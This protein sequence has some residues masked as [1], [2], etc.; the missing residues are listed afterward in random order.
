MVIIKAEAESSG[1]FIFLIFIQPVALLPC[2]WNSAG[3]PRRPGRRV[4]AKLRDAATL[5][6]R[7]SGGRPAPM[8]CGETAAVRVGL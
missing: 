7:Q 1:R 5:G 6:R 4:S 2:L 8:S 3:R